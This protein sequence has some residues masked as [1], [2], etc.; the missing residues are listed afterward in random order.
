MHNSNDE[1]RSHEL[2]HEIGFFVCMSIEALSHHFY[3]EVHYK[4]YNTELR[5]QVDRF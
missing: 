2:F 5:T 4:Y 1:N 3:V